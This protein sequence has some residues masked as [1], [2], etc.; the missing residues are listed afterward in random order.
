M[1]VCVKFG[2]SRSNR[3]RPAHFVIY[4]ERWWTEDTMHKA[5]RHTGLSPNKKP[6]NWWGGKTPRHIEFDPNPSEASFYNVFRCCFRP[7]VV[8]D[9]ISGADVGQVSMCVCTC[10]I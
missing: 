6:T 5:E 4:D 2:E 1:D 9:V 7:E 3:H 8:S 10:K